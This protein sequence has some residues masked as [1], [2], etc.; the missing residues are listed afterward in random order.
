MK[1]DFERQLTR[2]EF[3]TPGGVASGGATAPGGDFGAK[4][5]AALTEIE[6][7]TRAA[8]ESAEGLVQGKVDIHDA[9]VSMEK[10][11]LVLRL[12]TS[13]RNKLLD[14]YN[15]LMQSTRG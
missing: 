6:G 9:M 11:D 4:L 15:Q 5:S 13:V 2:P 14:A 8:D 12:S 10:A 1:I 3:P 7:T